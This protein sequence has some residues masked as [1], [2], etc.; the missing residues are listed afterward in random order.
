MLK[1]SKFLR[2]LL[3][4]LAVLVLLIG[5]LFIYLA[6]VSRVS[7]PDIK[8]TSSLSLQRAQPD[9]GLYT[10]GNNWFRK[11]HSGLYEL[12]VSGKPFERG[13][14]NGK[15]SEA[16]VKTQ[17][18]YFSER[19]NQMIPSPFYL[20]FLKYF[21]GWFNRDLSDNVT[22]EYKQEIY[23]VSQ[24]ASDGY[25]YIGTKY[26]RILN[27]HSAHDIG[28]ALQSMMLVG[29][30]CQN[31]HIH[32]SKDSTMIIGRNFDFWVGD[33]FAANNN[34]LRVHSCCTIGDCRPQYYP[35]QLASFQMPIP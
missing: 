27:Y 12:Y 26:S 34:R 15:L 23:G 29:C 24:S 9:S 22:S 19:I 13:V 20:R 11:S 14:I 1:R 2:R 7:P 35:A 4:T 25:Q 10:I 32:C 33:N 31:L 28:H 3:G 17:E 21:I 6:I 16:L 8:D 30:R 18:D 5:I